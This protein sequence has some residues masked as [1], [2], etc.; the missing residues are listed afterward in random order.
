ML[1]NEEV[2]ASER[3]FAHA[4][5]LIYTNTFHWQQQQ[6]FTN[7]TSTQ[8]PKERCNASQ[9]YSESLENFLCKS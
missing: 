2:C 3:A 5:T 1:A 8:E 4:H 9:L 7:Q 6:H